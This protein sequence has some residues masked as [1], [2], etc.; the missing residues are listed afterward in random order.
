MIQTDRYRRME[1]VEKD[2]QKISLFDLE[3]IF[4][5]SGQIQGCD[6]HQTDHDNPGLTIPE[7]T[8]HFNCYIL[9]AKQ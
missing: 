9:I 4:A 3:E 5:A 1:T 2:Q 7:V 8:E 6:Y